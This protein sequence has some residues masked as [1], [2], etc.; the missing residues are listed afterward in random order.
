MAEKL[1][2][3]IKI[4]DVL[5]KVRLGYALTLL[6]LAVKTGYSYTTVRS[7]QLRGLPV[8]DG[9]VTFEDFQIWKRRQTGLESSPQKPSHP[10]GSTAGRSC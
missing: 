10:R 7:W 1:L 8:L 3:K 9:K 6:E 2:S 5:E 4:E